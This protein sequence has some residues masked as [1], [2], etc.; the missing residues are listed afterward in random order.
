MDRRRSVVEV[1]FDKSCPPREPEFVGQAPRRLDGLRGEIEPHHLR[2]ELRQGQGITPEM[3]L[4]MQD[5]QP[6][7]RR[8]LGSFDRVQPAAAGA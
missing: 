6:G 2:A 8:Q 4:Q 7:N 5:A 3:T 1:R